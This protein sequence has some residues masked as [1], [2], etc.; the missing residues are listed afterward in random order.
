MVGGA[1]SGLLQEATR[2][3]RAGLNAEV[4]E[5]PRTRPMRV[6]A[7]VGI[8]AALIGAGTAPL[9]SSHVF[10]EAR[11]LSVGLLSISLAGFCLHATLLGMLAGVGRW[12]INLRR[13]HTH[14]PQRCDGAGSGRQAVEP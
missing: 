1:A 4:I 5:G 13:W 7:G 3:V 11:V 2:E 10:A 12:G 6:A 14:S 9:W 8:A